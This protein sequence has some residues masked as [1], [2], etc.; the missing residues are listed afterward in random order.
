MPESKE[1]TERTRQVAK[2]VSQVVIFSKGRS[3]EELEALTADT[4]PIMITP[5][6]QGGTSNYCPVHDEEHPPPNLT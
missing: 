5:L 3:V 6:I 4:K 1:I 2:A